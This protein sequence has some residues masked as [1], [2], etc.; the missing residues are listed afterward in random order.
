MT[1]YSGV[2]TFGDSLVDP[3]NALGLATWYGGLPFTEPV[4]AAPTA[5]KGYYD[6]RFTNGFT[7]ADLITNKYVGVASNAV[8][9]FGYKDPYL[10]VPIAP[11]ASDPSGNN[12]N[13]AYGGAQMRKGDEQVPDLDGQTDAWRDAVDGHAD[14]N[15]LH[16]FVFGANDVHDLVPKTGAWTDL[17]SATA[18][19][20]KAADKFIHEILQTIDDGVNHVLVTGVPDIGIQP[21]YNGLIDEAARRAVATQYAQILDDMIRTRIN[22]LSLP[23][24]V[25]FRYVSFTDMAD[26]VIGTLDDL[27]P[28]SQIYPLNQSSVV[29]FDQVHPTAQLHAMAAAYLLDQLNGTSSGDALPLA[30]PDYFLN[31]GINAKGEI[32]SVILSLAA[33]TT[34]T[35]QMLGLSS[36]GGNVSMLADPRLTVTTPGGSLLGGN[37]DG[38]VGLDASFTFTTGAAGDYVIGLSGVGSMTGTY[39]FQADGTAAANDT[40]YVKHSSAV[41]LEREGEGYDT[42]LASVSYALA[43]SASIE[44]LRTNSDQGKTSINLTGN[45]R[46]QTIVGNAGSNVIDGKG[47]TD[48][49]W[50]LTGKDDF[51]FSSALGPGNVDHIW[52]YNVRDDSIWLDDAVFT[53]LSLGQLANGAFAK[54]AAATQADDRIIYDSATGN[55]YFD[56]DGVGGL[57]EIHFATLAAGLKMTAS[58]FFVV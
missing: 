28:A 16:M 41:I 54:G 7:F 22:Q 31:G 42:V 36:L 48:S 43:D 32:D 51:L 18:T 14:P 39:R 19:L 56:P 55:L 53:G 58:D 49:M 40:Y 57:D 45:E 24:D 8:F 4:D 11:F 21:Y 6:G 2:I 46:A 12:L 37:D 23:S 27:Y 17:A 26:H 50:G 1:A 20:A 15:A 5:D 10:G 52:D 3:G 9:P 44:Q 13:F 25:E 33:N 34:Y 47:G 35:L 38:A 29:F 30:A